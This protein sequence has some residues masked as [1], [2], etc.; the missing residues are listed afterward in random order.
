MRRK[1]YLLGIDIDAT[2]CKSCIY[3]TRGRLAADGYAEY[4]MPLPDPGGV[5]ESSE[6]WWRALYTGT[7]QCLSVGIARDETWYEVVSDPLP[8]LPGTTTEPLG[9]TD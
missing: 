4:A 3:N 5:G 6:G 2:G 8:T 1:R 9:E 7:K